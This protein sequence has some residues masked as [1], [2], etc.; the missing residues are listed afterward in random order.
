MKKFYLSLLASALLSIVVL[1][2]L[3]DAFS[4]STHNSEDE[5]ALQSKLLMGFSKQIAAQAEQ[6]R[7][8]YTALLAEQFSLGLS[9]RATQSLALP[10][11]LLEQINAKGGL[12]L[13]DQE[14]FYLLYSNESLAPFHLKLRL[15]KPHEQDQQ[16]DM[17]LTLLFYAGLCV[18][19]GF[20][21]APLAKR[22]GVVNEAAKKFANGDLHARIRVS[23]FTY[24]KDVELT[25]NRMASQIEK[26]LDENKLMAT[27]LSHDIRTP[28][29]CLRFGLD[30]A[31]DSPNEEKR[32]HY[33]HRMEA[34]L[35]QMES[36][37]KSYLT[38]ATL[39]QKANQLTYSNTELTS[40][41]NTL[42]QQLEPKL[43]QRQ[44]DLQIICDNSQIHADLHW[45]ARA[46]TNLL[47]NACDFAKQKIILSA[48]STEQTLVI[49]VEDDGPGIAQ[50]NWHKVFNPFFQ[51][52]TH[53]NRADK[54]YGLGLAIVA[55]V[56]DWHHGVVTVEHS[57]KL[58]GACFTLKIHN[59]QQL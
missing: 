36:M 40:Y 22:L 33:L 27:S 39:E 19:M 25:F 24:I 28:I 42:A 18:F 44:L 59:A 45:L 37:L 56:V 3:I 23:H 20:I 52:Q 50:K 58:A 17:L 31:L 41:L 55:K 8:D 48:Y 47:S 21:I 4:Q 54:S 57:K 49:T 7:A 14:G 34:D 10:P 29:A 9:Y 26:L 2:W 11:S 6:Q 38:F 30:A 35:D 16:N 46:I 13:Q 12:T 53:R 32:E 15:D 1:G 43:L 51:E 5:F